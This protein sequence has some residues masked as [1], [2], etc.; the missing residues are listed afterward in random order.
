MDVEVVRPRIFFKALQQPP[1]PPLRMGRERP[2]ILRDLLR[3]YLDVRQSEVLLEHYGLAVF[4]LR[5]AIFR[6]KFGSKI[7]D[8]AGLLGS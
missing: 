2:E 4:S 3:I 6:L 1:E 5:L 8:R 7:V